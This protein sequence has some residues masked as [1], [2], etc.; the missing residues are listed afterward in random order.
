M[1]IVMAIVYGVLVAFFVW[2]LLEVLR[3]FTPGG[4]TEETKKIE[5]AVTFTCV[6]C[7]AIAGLIV[8]LALAVGQQ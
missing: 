1:N 8:F 4:I 6:S 2:G 3:P 7:G 5:E